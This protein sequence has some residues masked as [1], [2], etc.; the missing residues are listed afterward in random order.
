ML[1][2]FEYLKERMSWQIQINLKSVSVPIKTYKML[3][4]LGKGKFVDANL[5]ISKT[6]EVLATK[7]A[8]KYGYKEK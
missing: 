3:E 5:I 2:I 1:L 8:K 6:I 7:E 4:F